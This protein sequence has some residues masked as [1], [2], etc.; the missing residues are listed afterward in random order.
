MIVLTGMI[1]LCVT[2]CGSSRRVVSSASTDLRVRDLRVTEQRDTE[3]RDSVVV[4]ERDTVTVTKT[5]TVDRNEVGDTVRVSVVT[6]RERSRSKSDVRRLKEEGRW[7]R[8][9]VYVEK[10]DSCFVSNTDRTDRTDRPSGLIQTLW[11][12]LG[13]LICII[14]LVFIFKVK[15]LFNFN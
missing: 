15:R 4:V 13:I 10:R 12:V 2:A 9:T 1:V 6:D 14:I 5:I 11:R 7:K 3:V 8:D